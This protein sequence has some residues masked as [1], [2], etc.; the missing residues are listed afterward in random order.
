[1]L[2]KVAESML[3]LYPIVHL[4]CLEAF[5]KDTFFKEENVCGK[6][7]QNMLFSARS[8]RNSS[9]VIDKMRFRAPFG[10]TERASKWI[11]ELHKLLK[12]PEKLPVSENSTSQTA[13]YAYIT[14]SYLFPP[15]ETEE[16]TPPTTLEPTTPYEAAAQ[17]AQRAAQTIF[18][19]LAG[20]EK[21]LR[22]KNVSETSVAAAIKAI[23]IGQPIDFVNFRD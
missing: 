19:A 13:A 11:Q 23:D 10:I 15:L 6:A 4:G 2:T 9:L 21:E 1:M 8:S 18:R 17:K 20:V 22:A 3:F 5:L 14:M 16:S 12:V 7:L